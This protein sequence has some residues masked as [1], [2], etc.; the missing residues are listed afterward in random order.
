MA[1]GSCSVRG[2][3]TKE[4]STC[5]GAGSAA[6]DPVEAKSMKAA[7]PFVGF[8]GFVSLLGPKGKAV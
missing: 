1:T 7:T 5:L 4:T 3:T 2:E 6:I 8:I